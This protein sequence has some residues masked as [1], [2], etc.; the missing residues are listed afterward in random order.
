[1][2]IQIRISVF[3]YLFLLVVYPTI[4]L[5]TTLSDSIQYYIKHNAHLNQLIVTLKKELNQA[6]SKPHQQS[7]YYSP[8]S[9]IKIGTMYGYKNMQTLHNDLKTLLDISAHIKLPHNVIIFIR[10]L[11]EQWIS[12]PISISQFEKEKARFLNKDNHVRP[13]IITTQ[14]LAKLAQTHYKGDMNLA[15]NRGHMILKAY[16]QDPKFLFWFPVDMDSNTFFEKQS[17]LYSKD[18][19]LKEIYRYPEGQARYAQQWHNGDMDSAVEE[20]KLLIKIPQISLLFPEGRSSLVQFSIFTPYTA[21]DT[22]FGLYRYTEGHIYKALWRHLGWTAFPTTYS[23]KEWLEERSFF[24]NPDGQIKPEWQETTGQIKYAKKY[25]KGDLNKAWETQHRVFG[26]QPALN[27]QLPPSIDNHILSAYQLEKVINSFLNQ[28][29]QLKTQYKE[30]D[31]YKLYAMEHTGENLYNAFKLSRY[32]PAHLRQALNWHEYVGSIKDY[33]R[34]QAFIASNK[35]MLGLLTLARF[36]YKGNLIK[37]Y[38]NILSFFKGDKTA[39]FEHTGYLPF[40]SVGKLNI[41]NTISFTG[42]TIPLYERDKKTLRTEKGM[43]N[44]LYKGTEG[45]I[46]FANEYYAGDMHISFYNAKAV[47]GALFSESG[48]VLFPGTTTEFKEIKK[49]FQSYSIPIALSANTGPQ[50]VDSLT[51]SFIQANNLISFYTGITKEKIK[52][53]LNIPSIGLCEQKGFM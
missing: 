45:Y 33:K 36:Y 46:R 2:K 49:H 28:N 16:G 7:Q 42:N 37:A 10:K 15:K 12:D 31:G 50:M 5:S 23:A 4:T 20:G 9:Q 47:L 22:Q 13:D 39:L 21:V 48:W 35:G 38:R 11:L 51:K 14:G 43:L 17:R 19:S 30:S 40:F 32:L 44:P 29:K 6:S 3:C 34:D 27:W 24:V 1:M 26:N 18:G 52:A 41:G 8:Q 25:T 53:F